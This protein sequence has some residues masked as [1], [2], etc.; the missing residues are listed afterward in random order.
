[1]EAYNKGALPCTY[2]NLD[3]RGV[4]R[5]EGGIVEE[6]RLTIYVNAQ[7]VATLMCSPIEQEALALGF[8]FNEGVIASLDEVRLLRPNVARTSIDI[9]LNRERFDPPRRMVLTSGCGGGVTFQDL[10]ATHPPLETAFTSTPETVFALMQALKGAS[11][12]YNQVRGVHTS[13]LGTTEAMLISAEDIG[14]HNTID[15]LAGKALLEGIPTRDTILLT[16]GRI[17]SE[18]LIKARQMAVPLVASRTS[19]TGLTVQL[20]ETWN[21][22]VVGY[23]RRDSLRVYTH[24]YRLGLVEQTA[25]ESGSL[26]QQQPTL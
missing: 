26:P 11:T 1:M 17:S 9:F 14:R 18:M 22:C 25:Q 2:W 16:S 24:P 3:M 8:L 15:K 19:P 23:V 7:E 13:V 20:A 5:I 4:E 21:I 10:Q 6:A 12:L